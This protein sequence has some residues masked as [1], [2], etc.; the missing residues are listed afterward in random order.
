VAEADQ[1]AAAERQKKNKTKQ[2]TTHRPTTNKTKKEILLKYQ[3]Q[4]WILEE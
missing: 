4:D 1:A 2:N 3:H